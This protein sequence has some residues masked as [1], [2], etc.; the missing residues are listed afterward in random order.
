MRLDMQK[1]LGQSVLDPASHSKFKNNR[2]Y[3]QT[4]I[5]YYL[6]AGTHYRERFGMLIEKLN[7]EDTKPIFPT[8]VKR[9]GSNNG[10]PDY[11]FNGTPDDKFSKQIREKYIDS[12]KW[13]WMKD[14]SA[15]L[16]TYFRAL[17]KLRDNNKLVEDTV[18]IFKSDK[19]S[20]FPPPMD[21]EFKKGGG[22]K[23][24]NCNPEIVDRV[25]RVEA[26]A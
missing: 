19:K 5:D 3:I 2:S 18:S 20:I 13:D 4:Y 24:V 17:Q 1:W 14:F 6:Q 22:M 25:E 12:E 9:K 11:F 23:S 15:I 26:V 21:L 8:Y 16:D 10:L 7:Y